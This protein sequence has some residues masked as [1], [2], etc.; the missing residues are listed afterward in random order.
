MRPRGRRGSLGAFGPFPCALGIVGC[1]GPFTCALEVVGR[2]GEFAPLPYA[3]GVVRVRSVHSRAPWRSRRSIPVHPRGCLGV[4]GFVQV[5][6]VYSRAPWRSSDLFGC[7]RPISV[8]PGSRRVRRY[9][10]VRHRVRQVRS[11][12]FASHPYAL[13]LVRVRSVHSRAPWVS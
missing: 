11:G 9:I 7:F 8:R 10:P 4:V 12:A 3:L 1:V 5:P 2:S 6:S 13:G